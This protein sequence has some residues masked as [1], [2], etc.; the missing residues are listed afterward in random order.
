MEAKKELYEY[1]NI[2]ET[3]NYVDIKVLVKESIL[4]NM[5]VMSDEM[6]IY[7]RAKVMFNKTSKCEDEEYSAKS[8]IR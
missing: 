7:K 6:N 5:D 4:E 3:R 8:D 2:I 1:K